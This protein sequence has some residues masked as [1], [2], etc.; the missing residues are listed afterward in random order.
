MIVTIC[1]KSVFT[2]K[3]VRINP[4]HSMTSFE[5]LNKS[6]SFPQFVIE[7]FQSPFTYEE[8]ART[9]QERGRRGSQQD[10]LNNIEGD[11]EKL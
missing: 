7:D 1:C 8:T 11:D 5:N 4:N 10:F 6:S 9:M 2:Q 3:I